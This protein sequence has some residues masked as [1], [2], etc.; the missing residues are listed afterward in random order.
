MV[1]SRA[2]HVSQDQCPK[3]LRSSTQKIEWWQPRI[4]WPWSIEWKL[5]MGVSEKGGSPKP[6]VSVCFRTKMVEFWMIWG[7]TPHFRG[8]PN[9]DKMSSS[10]W[11]APISRNHVSTL[12]LC[13]VQ[14]V[15]LRSDT[16]SCPTHPTPGWLCR[17]DFGGTY[18]PGRET[19]K[20]GFL[21]GWTNKQYKPMMLLFFCVDK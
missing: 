17:Q 1:E 12:V 13:H 11:Q 2:T 10:T 21:A 7:A 8:P 6:L 3:D 5:Q 16:S 18:L 4:N 14:G 9:H 20:S 15:Q 19:K